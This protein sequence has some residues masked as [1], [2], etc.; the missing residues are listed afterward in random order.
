MIISIMTLPDLI[1]SN[2][3]LLI[4]NLSIEVTLLS[5]FKYG[6]SL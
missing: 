1:P 6:D 3:K 2:I 4:V 5:L